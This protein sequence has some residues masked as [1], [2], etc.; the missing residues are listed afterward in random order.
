MIDP[1]QLL[2]LLPLRPY[3]EIANVGCGLS[4]FTVSLAKYLFDGKLYAVDPQKKT[5]ESLA[6]LLDQIHLTNVELVQSRKRD[7]GLQ[8][9]SID[10]VLMPFILNNLEDKKTI[11]QQVLKAL[12]PSGWLA[13]LEWHAK[14]TKEGPPLSKKLAREESALITME[15]G[16]RSIEHRDIS[17]GEYMV[18]LRK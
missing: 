6:I 15:A 7:I 18:L 12:R 13:V 11:L 16:F 5:L 3:Q 4:D 9:E 10:G 14:D 17:T 2:S 8:D 1:T